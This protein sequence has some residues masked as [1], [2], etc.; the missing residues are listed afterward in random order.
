MIES[1]QQ[2]NLYYMIQDCTNIIA[3]RLVQMKMGKRSA[4]RVNWFSCSFRKWQGN[5]NMGI[6]LPPLVLLFCN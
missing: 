5:A 2:A 3:V 1:K 6:A 4:Q